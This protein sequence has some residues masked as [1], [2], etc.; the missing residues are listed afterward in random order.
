MVRVTCLMVAVCAS[1]IVQAT[2]KRVREN[3][4]SQRRDLDD[5]WAHLR[6][7][8]ILVDRAVDRF[9]SRQKYC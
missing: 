9:V 1:G 2:V 7:T 4:I 8:C 6:A 3:E 5:Y